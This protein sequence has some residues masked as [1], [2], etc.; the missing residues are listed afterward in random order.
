WTRDEFATWASRV[1]SERGYEV[2]F[3]PVGPEDPE[4]GA[5]TQMAVFTRETTFTRLGPSGEG[6]AAADQ[7]ASLDYARAVTT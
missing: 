3:A 1:A 6:P 7:D 2:R 4:V 5:P